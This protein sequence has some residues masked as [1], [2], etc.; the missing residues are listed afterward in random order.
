MYRQLVTVLHKA[1]LETMPTGWNLDGAVE[2]RTQ[3]Y[4]DWLPFR[5]KPSFKIGVPT[6]D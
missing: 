4:S 3:W 6:F 1:E 5:F 2:I